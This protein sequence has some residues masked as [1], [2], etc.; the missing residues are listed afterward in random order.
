MSNTQKTKQ[1]RM[2]TYL[3]IRVIRQVKYHLLTTIKSFWGEQNLQIITNILLLEEKMLLH[4]Q[5]INMFSQL[6]F[7]HD[8][9]L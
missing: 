1:K 8:I 9:F 3:T 6:V 2:H 7:I 4:M 5:V